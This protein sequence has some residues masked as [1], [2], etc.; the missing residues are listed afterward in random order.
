MLVDRERILD[1]ASDRLGLGEGR[2]WSH[3]TPWGVVGALISDQVYHSLGMGEMS[4]LL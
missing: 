2:L 4:T 1:R 3:Y